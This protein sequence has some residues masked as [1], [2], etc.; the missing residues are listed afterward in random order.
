VLFHQEQQRTQAVHCAEAK[1]P[2][3]PEPLTLATVKVADRL[4]EPD[5][6]TKAAPDAVKSHRPAPDHPWRKDIWPSKEAWRWN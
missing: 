6:A 5:T 3:P 1:L 2:P 4:P